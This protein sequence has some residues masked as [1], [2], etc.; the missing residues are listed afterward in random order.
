MNGR[1]SY[2]MWSVA[3]VALIFH[4]AAVGFI[5]PAEASNHDYGPDKPFLKHSFWDD[6]MAEV[7]VYRGTRVIYGTSRPTEEI[8][9]LVKEPWNPKLG[10]K[11]D[12]PSQVEAVKL[13]RVITTATGTYTYHQMLSGFFDRSGAGLLR[14]VLS[15]HEACGASYKSVIPKGKGLEMSY[16]TYWDG[17]GSGK[18]DIAGADADTIYFDNL[19]LHVRAWLSEGRAGE[20]KVKLFP[21]IL[22]SKLNRPIR[23]QLEDG[24][25]NV[26]LGKETHIVQVVTSLGK[27]TILVEA[28]YPFIMKEWKRPDGTLIKL[29]KTQRIPYWQLNRLGD[30]K[31]LE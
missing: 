29:H 27:E 30:E 28:Q 22:S 7:S 18:L 3:S 31:L 25:V 8:H 9:Y 13:N 11:S 16:H 12:T 21:T 15:H 20:F 26:I 17:E 19:P 10:V 24:L 5:P 23:A 6:G 14:L 4:F 2:L 1:L